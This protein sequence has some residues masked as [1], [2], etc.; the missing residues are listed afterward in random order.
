ME[1]RQRSPSAEPEVK[2]RSTCD[3]CTA[4]KVRCNKQKPKCKRCRDGGSECVYGPYRWRG[5]PS[6]N[7]TTS[8]TAPGTGGNTSPVT[9]VAAHATMSSQDHGT[10]LNLFESVDDSFMVS[11]PSSAHERSSTTMSAS[12]WDSTSPTLV[13][14]GANPPV[15]FNFSEPLAGDL[16]FLG[17]LSNHHP[18]SG[19][20][21]LPGHGAAS[22]SAEGSSPDTAAG[23][24]TSNTHS[25]V[26]G[27][28]QIIQGLHSSPAGNQRGPESDG[29]LRAN[30]AAL[31]ELEQILSRSSSCEDC[32]ANSNLDFLLY[33]AGARMLGWYRAV[34]SC[35]SP[36]ATPRTSSNSPGGGSVFFRAVRLSDF[37]LDTGSERR[38]NSMLLL[39]ELQK[40][41]KFLARLSDERFWG[42]DG[43]S[44]G[45]PEES[46]AAASS[47]GDTS[48]SSIFRLEQ[49]V[50][51]AFDD[52]LTA[53]VQDL[54]RSVDN[55]CK[56]ELPRG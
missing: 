22:T 50:L 40:L 54:T 36:L 6:S 12:L 48:N 23:A 47:V 41:A 24:S 37:D 10:N 53:S 13:H 44:G 46:P 1:R 34:F 38:L 42:R 19:M 43:G 3:R 5:R 26:Q 45:R 17:D 25:C 35:L 31:Q 2:L 21:L 56:S 9:H 52:F 8:S 28:L 16:D 7:S 51:E 14:S 20:T 55:A 39:F 32:M 15:F 30:S 29:I 49:N 33:T 11:N 4:L 18:H 27:V